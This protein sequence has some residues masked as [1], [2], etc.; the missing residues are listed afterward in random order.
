MAAVAVVV[1]APAVSQAQYTVTLTDG[2]TNGTTTGSV[3]LTLTPTGG[4]NTYDTV[5]FTSYTG[6]TSNATALNSLLNTVVQAGGNSQGGL[7]TIYLTSANSASQAIS[8]AS[9]GPNGVY[10]SG[11][12]TNINGLVFDGFTYSSQLAINST[13][14][15]TSAQLEEN[16]NVVSNGTVTSQGTT[17]TSQST[18]LAIAVSTTYSTPVGL[19]SLSGSMTVLN[20]NPGASFVGTVTYNPATT[21]TVVTTGTQ[22]GNPISAITNT[23]Y[24][25]AVTGYTLQDSISVTNFTSNSYIGQFSLTGDV[26]ATP[27]PSGL[28]LGATM[29]P[30]FGVLRRRIRGLAV[31]AAA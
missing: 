16:N 1:V 9:G 25:N 8:I 31:K 17:L 3:T 13:T 28:L 29:V 7:T 22:T 10:V 12:S 14:S 11:S 2:P 19:S 26:L 27:A 4:N 5:T 23:A 21:D 6:F 18:S 24:V 20:N 15:P 30:F